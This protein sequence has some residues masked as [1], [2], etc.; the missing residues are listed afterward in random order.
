[1]NYFIAVF[2]IK[3]TKS[4]NNAIGIPKRPNPANGVKIND[5]KNSEPRHNKASCQNFKS[6]QSGKAETPC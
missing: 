5:N 2:Y 1:M 4:I 6:I 3:A